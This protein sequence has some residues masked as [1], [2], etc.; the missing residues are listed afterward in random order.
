MKREAS[1]LLRRFLAVSPVLI[2]GAVTFSGLHVGNAIYRYASAVR[3]NT[4]AINLQTSAVIVQVRE[5][6]AQRQELQRAMEA[7]K[8]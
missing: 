8:P 3:M 1:R 2:A 6:R 7:S 5:L 4:H